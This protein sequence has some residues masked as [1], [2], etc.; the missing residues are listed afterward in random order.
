M[1]E[2]KITQVQTLLKLTYGIIPIVA[3]ADKFTNLLTDWAQYLHPALA[4]MLPFSTHVFM[5]IVGVIEI[6][7]GVLVLVNPAK[8]GYL[9]AAWLFLIALS[10]LASGKF[11]DVAVRD[12]V[13]AIGAYSLAQISAAIKKPS[14]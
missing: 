10:L 6:V 1:D 3:G 2:K 7:A 12:I 5:M 4:G 14:L 8:A 9:V 13:M 11:I